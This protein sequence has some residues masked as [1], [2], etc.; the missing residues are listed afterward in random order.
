V[1]WHALWDF[2]RVFTRLKRWLSFLKGRGKALS[3][4]RGIV[5]LSF[6]S[7]EMRQ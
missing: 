4:R 1:A 2:W 7:K 5:A 6:F 3:G